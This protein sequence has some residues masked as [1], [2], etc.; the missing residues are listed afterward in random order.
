LVEVLWLKSMSTTVHSSVAEFTSGSVVE[1]PHF[2]PILYS[3]ITY[4]NSSILYHFIFYLTSWKP[5]S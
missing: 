1:M 4:L 3:K 5:R 2:F